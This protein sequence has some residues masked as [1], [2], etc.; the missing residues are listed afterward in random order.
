M[1]CSSIVISRTN[2]FLEPTSTKQYG[3]SFLLKETPG[4][5]D[6]ART[7]DLHITS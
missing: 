5:F 4:A 2:V 1:Y 6:G 3:S 7:H